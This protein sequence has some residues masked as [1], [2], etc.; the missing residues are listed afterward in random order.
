MGSPNIPEN[1]SD[2]IISIANGIEIVTVPTMRELGT[3][4]EIDV[5]ASCAAIKLV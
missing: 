1:I 4:C 5:P 2:N 3:L